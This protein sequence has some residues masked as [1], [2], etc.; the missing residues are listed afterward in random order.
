MNTPNVDAGRLERRVRLVGISRMLIMHRFCFLFFGLAANAAKFF[1][2]LLEKLLTFIGAAITRHTIHNKKVW[3]IFISSCVFVPSFVQGYSFFPAQMKPELPDCSFVLSVC[4]FNP[5]TTGETASGN[6]GQSIDKDITSCRILDKIA[7]NGISENNSGLN[8]S[9]VGGNPSGGEISNQSTYNGRNCTTDYIT[10][11]YITHSFMKYFVLSWGIGVGLGGL[12]F[13]LIVKIVD[14]NM[15]IWFYDT[16]DLI[17]RRKK[18]TPNARAKGRGRTKLG[19]TGQSV[20]PRPLERRVGLPLRRGS[21]G[22]MDLAF[23]SIF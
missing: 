18:K 4:S 1:K 7:V 14:G 20:T 15:P 2:P 19:E 12:L 6:A 23:E 3:I 13:F 8:F 10:N 17:F 9:T 22:R 21:R 16:Y 5:L 11:N